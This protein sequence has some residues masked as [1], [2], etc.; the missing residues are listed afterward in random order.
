MVV[1]PNEIYV[2]P[3]F[4]W[5]EFACH[6]QARTA[7][8]REWDT[9]LFVLCTE[10]E[11]IRND[12][13][14]KSITVASGYRTPQ[15][16]MLIGGAPGSSHKD[17]RGADFLSSDGINSPHHLLLTDALQ[18]RSYMPESLLRGVGIYTDGRLH[19][20][21]R[22]SLSGYVARWDSWDGGDVT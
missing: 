14:G 2:T 5:I 3:H 9:R 6:D 1:F 15:H 16:N 7:Y 17:G 22:I 12:A 8:P 11:W 10:L 20:D 19:A 21:I 18:K 4:R 13:G